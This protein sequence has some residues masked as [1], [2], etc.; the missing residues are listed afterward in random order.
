MRRDTRSRGIAAAGMLML[1]AGCGGG[2]GG[3]RT[4]PP[5]EPRADT[6]PPLPP[7]TIPPAVTFLFGVEAGVSGSFRP[8]EPVR[9]DATVHAR[10]PVD[11]ADI[12]IVMPEVAAAQSSGWG[13]EFE[14]R[15]EG[16]AGALDSLLVPMRPGV[17]ARLGTEVRLP[18]GYY[19]VFVTAR[20]RALDPGLRSTEPIQ[21]LA[22]R[23]FWI[24]I[25][26]YGGYVSNQ[27]DQTRFPL[28]TL[29]QPGPLRTPAAMARAVAQLDSGQASP[30]S[31]AVVRG[32]VRT[33]DGRPAQGVTVHVRAYLERCPGRGLAE[34]TARTDAEGRYQVRLRG[35]LPRPAAACI[36]VHADPPR[37]SGWPHASSV[38]E[39]A[40]FVLAQHAPP[41]TPRIDLTLRPQDARGHERQA[42]FQPRRPPPPPEAAPP[43]GPAVDPDT[44]PLA[45]PRRDLRYALALDVV[46]DPALSSEGPA[47]RAAVTVTNVSRRAVR[48]SYTGCAVELAA[49][50]DSARA[51]PPLWQSERSSTW[52]AG[53]PRGCPLPAIY[54][55]LAPGESF[56]GRGSDVGWLGLQLPVSYVYADSLPAGRYFFDTVVRLN[57]DT[58]QVRGGGT[59]LPPSRFTL[60]PSYPLDGFHYAAAARP[61]ESAPGTYEVSVTVRNAGMR[62]DLTRSVARDCPV[63]LHAYR[64]AEAQRSVPPRPAWV[65][66][67]RCAPVAEDVRLRTGQERVFTRRFTAREV[68]GDSLPRGRWFVTAIVPLVSE[69]AVTKR[70]W[71][72]AGAFDLR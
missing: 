18:A 15:F 67:R 69:G 27:L 25:S 20:A 42:Q 22:T 33:P 47:L 2:G 49:W 39:P 58:V 41:D 61:V 57:R 10:L 1:L 63:V 60:G 16:P 66:P 43:S 72:D 44:V 29:P 64:T 30:A 21:D 3:V 5:A 6:V 17:P 4:A 19:Q 31:H 12:R 59:V 34:E 13:E 7:P 54:A 55:V 56:T 46:D 24:W 68:L 36:A 37:A 71:L 48:L 40:R 23:D 11:T 51:R 32:T 52:P 28:R 62:P 26:E 14:R 50:R 38:G 35:W 70:I 8:G 53:I 65:S 9:I 45:D